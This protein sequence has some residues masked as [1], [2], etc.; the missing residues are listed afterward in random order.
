MSYCRSLC[1]LCVAVCESL[2][3]EFVDGTL[4]FTPL[5]HVAFLLPLTRVRPSSL[6]DMNEP[7]TAANAAFVEE[8]TRFHSLRGTTLKVNSSHSFTQTRGL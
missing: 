7:T 1:C 4:Q 3:D 6:C 8:L 2:V 5:F